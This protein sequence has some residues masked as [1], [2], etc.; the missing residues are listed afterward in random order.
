VSFSI[1]RGEVLVMV[2]ENGAGKST[3][4]NLLS[5]RLLPDRGRILFGRKEISLESPARAVERGIGVV[6]QHYAL[7]PTLNALDNIALAMPELGHGRIDRKRLAVRVRQL[8][9]ELGFTI[10][11]TSNIHTLDVAE[12]QRVEIVKAL[13]RSVG[14]LLLDEPTAVLGPEDKQRLFAM[15]RQLRSSGV[16]IVL[17]THKLQDIAAVADR[18]VILR[19]GEVVGQGP[20]SSFDHAAIVELMVGSRDPKLAAEVEGEATIATD[21]PASG[22]EVF[23]MRDLTLRRP[24]GSV[25]VAGLNAA[26]SHGEILAIAGVD[27]NGQAE[28]V[29]CLTGAETPA[30]GS[31][32]VLGLG[33]VH[34]H[35]VSV[36]S[37]RLAGLAHIPADR[38]RAGIVERLD[39]A[40]N[41]LLGN[42]HDQR[43]WRWGIVRY[44]PLVETVQHWIK[45]FDI[46]T[47]GP[48]QRIGALSGGNQQKF[49]VAREL[50]HVPKLLIAA[51]PTR[52][53]DVRTTQFV[54]DRLRQERQR[55]AAI[56]LVSGD[57]DEVLGLADRIL[58]LSNGQAF[59]PLRRPETSPREI[60][61]LIAGHAAIA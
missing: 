29:R 37:L 58:I 49:V 34:A 32:E 45:A 24:D 20:A 60:G 3:I 4:V 35:G 43:F 17:I 52:G 10:D 11:L 25:A 59:G 22:S 46:R 23:R 7:V 51:H 48:R 8:A 39:L 53:L 6:H 36:D 16:A 44:R 1:N 15:I 41:F 61:A 21:V 54:H 50:A 14:V 30:E 9:D 28:L 40:D 47:V 33:S 26:L 12:Q 55:G 18:V 19:G 13:V 31:V 5:G 57:L 2:G 42:T 38:R 56:L 27:G